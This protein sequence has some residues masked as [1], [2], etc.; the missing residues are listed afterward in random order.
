MLH[1]IS[2]VIGEA[3]YPFRL[4][5]TDGVLA[6]QEAKASLGAGSSE[7][8]SNT[9]A[10]YGWGARTLMKDNASTDV[11]VHGGAALASFYQC[12]ELY[13]LDPRTL[14][15][16]GKTTW[17]GFFPAEGVSAHPKVDEHTGELLFFSYFTEAPYMRYG[18]VS[19]SGELTNHVD[20]PLPGPRLPHDMAFTENWSILNLSLIHI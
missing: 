6:E 9:T 12:G 19:R 1:S 17:N 4:V 20:I 18:V 15:D 5:G 10:E 3:H 2:C 8:P 13:R 11:I 16:L 7:H 14:E